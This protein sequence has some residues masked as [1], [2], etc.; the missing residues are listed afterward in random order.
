V[1][2]E[3]F[4]LFPATIKLAV[5]AVLFALLLRRGYQGVIHSRNATR[6]STS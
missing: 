6:F 3:F 5:C 2:S 1:I 4:A